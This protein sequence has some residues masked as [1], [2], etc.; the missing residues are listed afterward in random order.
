[1]A[2]THSK[3]SISPPVLISSQNDYSDIF[4]LR[5]LKEK[6]NCSEL[7]TG[8]LNLTLESG[9]YDCAGQTI[10]L[11]RQGL[12]M[13]G[14]IMMDAATV[15][16]G[17]R[18]VLNISSDR[19]LLESITFWGDWTI[20]IS[21]SSSVELKTVVIDQANVEIRSGGRFFA[22]HITVS[23]RSESLWALRICATGAL[24]EIHHSSF[25]D[26]S[27]GSLLLI[28]GDSNR[29]MLYNTTFL[30]A[31]PLSSPDLLSV[32]V[33]GLSLALN[34]SNV[35][36]QL[37]SF[38]WCGWRALKLVG[39]LTALTLRESYFYENT[40]INSPGDNGSGGAVGAE[41]PALTLSV[42][43]CSMIGQWADTSGGGIALVGD[44][45]RLLVQGTAINANQV[46]EAGGAVY[47]EGLRGALTV[48]DCQMSD[49]IVFGFDGGAVA[50][51]SEGGS[52]VVRGGSFERNVVYRSGGALYLDAARADILQTVITENIAT[53]G[54][55][56][57]SR[58]REL[59][60]AGSRIEGNFAGGDSGGG[61]HQEFCNAASCDVA[62]L[63]SL[64]LSNCTILNNIAADGGGMSTIGWSPAVL[65][66]CLIQGNSAFGA[67]G[68]I[69]YNRTGSSAASHAESGMM[70]VS[71]CVVLGNVA[72]HGDGGGFAVLNGAVRVAGV[73]FSGNVAKEG[74][75]GGLSIG[76]FP[77]GGLA[78]AWAVE[79]S[80]FHGNRAA[81]S[82][83]ALTSS[84]LFYH[85][86]TLSAGLGIPFALQ[87]DGSVLCRGHGAFDDRSVVS[88][89]SGNFTIVTNET[90]FEPS[91]SV[92]LDSDALVAGI[93]NDSSV[94]IMY[95]NWHY[96]LVA[97]N[98]SDGKILNM[99][100][101][102]PVM[103]YTRVNDVAGSL[104]NTLPVFIPKIADTNY[105]WY[106][107]YGGWGLSSA[108]ISDMIFVST[109]HRTVVYSV[110]KNTFTELS[111][112]ETGVSAMTQG[113]SPYSL[114]LARYSG[115]GYTFFIYTYSIAD[116]R[117]K[118]YEWPGPEPE[119]KQIRAIGASSDGETLFLAESHELVDQVQENQVI[120]MV[121]L[122]SGSVTFLYSGPSSYLLL[123]STV[124]ILPSADGSS[125]ELLILCAPGGWLGGVDGQKPIAWT[126]YRIRSGALKISKTVM[127]D[128][129]ALISGGSISAL[130][131]SYVLISACE[132][133]RNHATE[134]GGAIFASGA[135]VI[136]LVYS[137][138]EFNNAGTGGAMFLN[139]GS[140]VSIMSSNFT[141]NTAVTCGGA[142]SM[143]SS[144]YLRFF[145]LNFLVS[146][147]AET[148]GGICSSPSINN[149]CT[150]LDFQILLPSSNSFVY[151][152][153]NFAE[154][155]GG[156]MFDTCG[157]EYAA[158]V[159][160]LSSEAKSRIG[161]GA[162]YFNGNMAGYGGNIASPP[163]TFA[164]LNYSKKL[165]YYPGETVREKMVVQ[166]R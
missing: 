92:L 150:D 111:G 61:V 113:S 122:K 39:S 125:T 85:D 102:P 135:S 147:V 30:S 160:R 95:L 114:I 142:I 118:R 47:F 64:E 120:K 81:K 46:G 104:S 109:F 12:V 25:G 132:F 128:N 19:V 26:N 143:S 21:S 157:T 33:I 107:I 105:Y 54:G 23:R 77:Y 99:T 71:G 158:A 34:N 153:Y 124:A 123:D 89:R 50:F 134:I 94:V 121:N 140:K 91:E 96:A 17:D 31:N 145:G 45:G 131:V 141:S 129:D 110:S 28:V 106:Y 65:S 41:G 75:G 18:S 8:K 100:S 20:Y 84:G 58:V 83:G 126:V 165:Y 155:G 146:N 14:S 72:Q 10:F 166:D 60:M 42:I 137:L 38:Q 44:D 9:E 24:V 87:P 112:C 159:S 149:S 88:Y 74:S 57:Y 7:H 49:N 164:M 55:G 3:S 27:T 136:L 151:M 144:Q 93:S 66:G 68:G 108:A 2:P 98:V 127:R 29:I 36:V 43:S 139:E 15:L 116:G 117:C 69:L 62:D 73:N 101:S 80:Q 53:G 79:D 133:Y 51:L 6:R 11:T 63:G 40:A 154:Q 82:G 4:R 119:F 162:L 97:I 16:L 115:S 163:S 48:I 1:M 152:Q 59:R 103:A 130:D 148:G 22:D 5:Q 156:A 35:V 67:G 161:G 52:A 138:L 78:G 90:L 13:K 86:E 70:V 32:F 56:V 76:G 37:C